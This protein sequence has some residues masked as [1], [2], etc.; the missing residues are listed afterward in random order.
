MPPSPLLNCAG[1]LLLLSALFCSCA[2][3]TGDKKSLPSPLPMIITRISAHDERRELRPPVQP[4]RPA[5]AAT[6]MAL[7]PASGSAVSYARPYANERQ[8]SRLA[9]PLPTGAWKQLWQAE[10]RS[11]F[12][13]TFV[14]QDGD[15]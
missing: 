10:V 14:L 4:I 11:D 13:P 1:A 9:E 6:G 12:K 5:A 8:N 3:A 15:R 7:A 2:A